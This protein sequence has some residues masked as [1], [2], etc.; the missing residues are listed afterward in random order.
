MTVKTKWMPRKD[1]KYNIDIDQRENLIE[2]LIS[3]QGVSAAT[4]KLLVNRGCASVEEGRRYLKP[5]MADLHDPFLFEDM[6]KVVGRIIQARDRGEK[7]YLYGD[8]DADG[9]IGV[10][11]LLKFMRSQDFKVDYFIPNR[12]KTGYGLH[13]TP[14]E[15]LIAGGTKLIITIDN[16]ITAREQIDFCNQRNVDVIVTDHHECHGVLP[17]AFGIINPKRPNS[18][19]PF[20]ELCGAGVAFKLVQAL[21]LRL[22]A[23]LDLQESIECVALATV[24]D[25]V[26]LVDENR[27]LVFLGLQYLNTK[28]F[29]PGIRALM[30]VSE[31]LVLKAWHF[32]FVLGPKINAAGRLGEANRIVELLTGIDQDELLILAEFLSEENRKR[33]DLEKKILAEAMEVVESDHLFEEDVLVVGGEDWHSGVIGIVASRLQEKYYGPVVVIGI[34]NGIGKGSCRSIEGF[35]IFEALCSCQDLFTS[36]GGHALAA[37]FSLPMENIAKLSQELN[38]YGRSVGLKNH[39]VKPLYYDAE[40]KPEE[41]SWERL[42]EIDLFEPCG[43]GNPGIQ[44]MMNNPVLK[45]GG[46]MGKEKNHLFLGFE[47]FRGVGFGLGSFFDDLALMPF[48]TQSGIELLCRLDSN[49]YQGKKSLQVVIKDLKKNPIWELETAMTLVKLI[50]K[51]KN[52]KPKIESILDGIF[53]GELALDRQMILGVYGLMKKSKNREISI[54]KVCDIYRELSP[55]HLLL[56]CETLREAGIIAY[57]LK[58][59]TIIFKIIQTDE[60]KDIQKTK[61]M[62]KLRDILN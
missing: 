31:L 16:G 5:A 26:P 10:S 19:Y 51:E 2:E 36:F 15:T 47:G 50:V 17:E 29:N 60:K 45:S 21:G 55:L 27:T 49:E 13:C 44:F 30:A 7:I 12:L 62:L 38:E 23:A 18:T 54:Q 25:L 53:P 8:Y 59:G 43:I 28:P 34:E 52:P 40:I 41:V 48:G 1:K 3:S 6:E 22:G 37:G 9:T 20:K 57:A 42:K 61:L 39:L 58:N 4:A 56:A 35:N 32:G 24:A 11:V 14:L 46:T 33:Q